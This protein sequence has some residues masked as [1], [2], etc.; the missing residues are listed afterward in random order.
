[1]CFTLSKTGSCVPFPPHSASS[2]SQKLY[3]MVLSIRDATVVGTSFLGGSLMDKFGRKTMLVGSAAGYTSMAIFFLLAYSVRP[4]F[5]CSH[6]P[7][8]SLFSGARTTSCCSLTVLQLPNAPRVSLSSVA[9]AREHELELGCRSCTRRPLV[10]DH[11]C[12]L[13][14]SNFFI[15]NNIYGSLSKD[16]MHDKT[17]SYEKHLCVCRW[18]STRS[19]SSP[20]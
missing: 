3:S 17:K 11:C 4:F 19:S 18:T 5:K 14:S 13:A 8:T 12:L 15:I 16:C 6:G 20:R 2:E 7:H 1:M 10:V 9:F